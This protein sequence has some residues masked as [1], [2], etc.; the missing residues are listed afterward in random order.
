MHTH[1]RETEPKEEEWLKEGE[2]ALKK[3]ER[4][5][6]TRGLEKCK[7]MCYIILLHAVDSTLC[8]V[9][10]INMYRILKFYAIVFSNSLFTK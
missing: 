6:D 7:K 9:I 1:M 3:R 5:E 8:V 10:S 4:I 2:E